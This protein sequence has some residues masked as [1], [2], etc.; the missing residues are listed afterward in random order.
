MRTIIQEEEIKDLLYGATYFGGGG[1]GAISA[2]MDMLMTLAASERKFELVT[3]DEMKANE[4]S[5]MAAGLGSPLSMEEMNFGPEAVYVVEGMMEYAE[6]MGRP[7]R[8]IYSGEQGGFNTM[9]PIYAAI[10]KN[11]PVLDTDGNGRAVPELNTG[12]LPIYKIPT[13]P[14]VLAN[15]NGDIITGTTKDPLDST[16]C[17]TI[18]RQMCQAYNN[19]IGFSTW[20]M[21]REQHERASVI[22]Q[23]LLSIKMGGILRKK[24][25][26]TAAD[27]LKQLKQYT[28]VRLFAVGTITKIDVRTENGF[29]FG[30][31]EITDDNGEVFTVDFKNENLII[32]SNGKTLLTVPEIISI[33]REE[34]W[35]PL[36][37][38][39][40]AVGMRVFLMGT[41]ADAKWWNI[42]EGYGCWEHILK[43]IGYSLA[44]PAVEMIG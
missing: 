41:R 10:K 37:N 29:D 20:L 40:T 12:L 35:M 22:G 34:D 7:V 1:G 6:N 33:V 26:K 42:R 18:A 11:L 28:L 16:A 44:G 31:T 13:S 8:Y 5:A 36:S 3:V 39:E 17:E 27:L 43:L 2:G 38:A 19:S 21:D 15:H 14:L 30:V 4:T 23:M 32:R 25:G 24:D 9:V